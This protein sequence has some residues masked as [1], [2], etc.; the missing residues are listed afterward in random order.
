[1]IKAYLKFLFIVINYSKIIN[2][3]DKASGKTI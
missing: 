2:L 3:H 1:M